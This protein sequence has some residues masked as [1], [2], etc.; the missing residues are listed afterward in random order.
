[1]A[2]TGGV[3]NP[4]ARSLEEVADLLSHRTTF[5]PSV[6]TAVRENLSVLKVASRIIQ[7]RSEP[8]EPTAVD[9]GR[10]PVLLVPG[11]AATD[12]ALEP[13]AEALRRRGHWTSRSGIG[14]NVGCT[15]EMADA[16]ERRLEVVAERVGHRVAIVGWSRGGT[17]GKVV[18][19]R[20]PD[21]VESL[22]TLGTPNTHPLAVSETLSTQINLLARLRALGVPGLLDQD[23]LS[24]ECARSVMAVLEGPFPDG[25]SY[26]AVFSMEDGVIDWR[27][28]L[29]PDAMHIECSATH[30]GMG[31]DPEVIEIVCGV[32]DA[33]E[34]RPLT[35]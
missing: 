34:P 30:M 35:D 21:L 33:V 11:F 2:H 27:A 14:P 10:V 26:T 19:V 17:L 7:Q 24:G 13:M 3:E 15:Q 5:R 31:A 1:V 20:R 23:C 4:V 9:T 22:V 29:D 25:I 6:G 32:L 16:L 8:S 28:C 12:I 18:A